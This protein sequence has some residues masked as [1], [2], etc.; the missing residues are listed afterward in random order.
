[1]QVIVIVASFQVE[2]LRCD[3]MPG[4]FHVPF[5]WGFSK[6]MNQSLV[7]VGLNIQVSENVI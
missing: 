5:A 7:V 3:C 6:N 4:P 1:M 2:K